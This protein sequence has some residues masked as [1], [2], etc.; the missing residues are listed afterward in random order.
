MSRLL[1]IKGPASLVGEAFMPGDK[2]ISHRVALLASIADGASCVRGFASSADCQSTLDCLKRLGVEIEREGGLVRIHGR[3]MRGFESR[4]DGVKLY[5]GNSGSTIRMLAGLLAAQPFTSEIDGDESIRRRP[6]KRV[7]DPLTKMGARIQARDGNYAPITISGGPLQAIDFHSPVASAQV[8]TA[9]MLAG[10]YAGGRTSVVEPAPSRNHTELML[11]EF[12]AP[13][14][15]LFARAVAVSGCARLRPLEYRVAGD[16]SSAAFL[17]AGAAFLPGSRLTVKDVCLNPTRT[18]FLD[19]L[20]MLGARVERR[21][22]YSLHGETVGDLYVEHSGPSGKADRVHLGGE[23]IANIIDEIPI[24][25]V[26]ATQY[27]GTFEVREAGELRHKESD[28]VHAVVEAINALGGRAEEFEDGFSIR[29]PQ[30]LRG[31]RVSTEGDHRIAM[32]FSIA[33]LMAEGE[34]HIIGADSAAVSFPE[35]YDVLKQLA[36]EDRIVG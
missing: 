16:V 17:V 19:V 12:G 15:M 2:S 8:K 27:E 4:P 3:G 35:F 9:V 20:E 34:T 24:L 31:G 11:K 32:A 28:R 29:G 36:G 26:A 14:E 13:V 5:A 22:V 25:A 18:A 30:R 7:I 21:N 6:M 10:L 1:A 33:G 23:I